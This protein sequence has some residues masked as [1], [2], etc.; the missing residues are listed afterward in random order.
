MKRII[1]VFLLSTLILSCNKDDEDIKPNGVFIEVNGDTRIPS[2]SNTSGYEIDLSSFNFSGNS[3]EPS[4]I[5][6]VMD[7]YD[8]DRKYIGGIGG[9]QSCVELELFV[10]VFKSNFN[11]NETIQ[12]F[13]TANTKEEKQDKANIFIRFKDSSDDR[14]MS[15]TALDGQSVEIE[16]R[17][18]EY[19]VFF[20][21]LN[22]K[23]TDGTDF[24]ASSRIITN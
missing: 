16:K 15:G 2:L 8:L 19:Y 23:S 14:I 21:N 10:D 6:F 17:N 4:G 24:T 9:I 1:F 5:Q 22:F 18:G 12:T 13:L 3:S 11:G 7:I 20:D